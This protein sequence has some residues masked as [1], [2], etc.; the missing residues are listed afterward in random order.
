MT[1]YAM[2]YLDRHGDKNTH[3]VLAANPQIAT[4]L[5]FAA[6]HNCVRVISCKPVLS[7]DTNE[8]DA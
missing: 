7:T 1:K 6:D 3:T 4:D 5:A 8:L 2:V